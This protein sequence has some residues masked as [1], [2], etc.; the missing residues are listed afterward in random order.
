[1]DADIKGALTQIN[2]SYKAFTH[3]GRRM[4][5]ADVKRVLEYAISKGYKHTEQITDSEVDKILST[6]NQNKKGE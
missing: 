3:N 5:K 1:M 4:S 2:I 6:P